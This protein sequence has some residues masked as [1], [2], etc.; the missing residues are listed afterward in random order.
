MTKSLK[1]Q[2]SGKWRG[3]LLHL[4]H[5][6]FGEKLTKS[7]P[8]K[9]HDQPTLLAV[10][11]SMKKH[12]FNLLV[13]GV[14][15]AV[16]YTQFPDLK[17]PYSVPISELSTI[18]SEAR[19]NGL[20]FVPKLNFAKSPHFRHSEWMGV[21]QGQADNAEFWERAFRLIDEVLSATQARILHV[22]M[23]EDDTRSP[24]EYFS[25]LSTLYAYLKKKRVRMAMWVD[26]DQGWRPSNRWKVE[27]ALEKL[28]RD[29]LLFPWCYY[30]ALDK[31]VKRLTEMGFDVVGSSGYKVESHWKEQGV[32]TNTRQWVESIRNQDA[33]GVLVT[34]WCK[35]D[36]DTRS[37]L[38]ES[39]RTC[40]PILNELISKLKSA[41]TAL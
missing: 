22:G 38:L 20:E 17:R 30:R 19:K 26:I 28:P 5:D 29:V 1:I 35:C 24:E 2:N 33:A 21:K 16:I 25:A 31:S 15:D 27:P 34:H 4:I 9:R 37:L 8:E 39:V 23:D 11:R 6:C 18:A 32:S 12:Q 10:I 36:T 40:G 3:L 41:S 7:P 13:L 14:E